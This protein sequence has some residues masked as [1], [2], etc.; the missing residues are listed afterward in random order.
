MCLLLQAVNTTTNNLISQSL[1]H[2]RVLAKGGELL[3]VSTVALQYSL[4]LQRHY[5]TNRSLELSRTERVLQQVW[6]VADM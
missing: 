2:S 6:T 5:M 3:A 4:L 1:C